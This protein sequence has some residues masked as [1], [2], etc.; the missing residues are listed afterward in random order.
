MRGFLSGAVFGVLI[1]A[2]ALIMMS[3]GN[4]M[5]ELRTE[6]PE[7]APVEVPA[8]SEFNRPP[9]ETDPVVPSEETAPVASAAPEVTAPESTM[10]PVPDTVPAGTPDL[11]TE[12]ETALDQPAAPEAGPEMALAT[13]PIAPTSETVRPAAPAAEAP[14]AVQPPDAETPVEVAAPEPEPAP[15][16]PDEGVSA[17]ATAETSAPSPAVAPGV[18]TPAAMEAAPV[19][20]SAPAAITSADAPALPAAPE[21]AP[22][23]TAAP[24]ENASTAIAATAPPAAPDAPS[25][26]TVASATTAPPSA[27]ESPAEEAEAEEPAETELAVPAAAESPAPLGLPEPG[28]NG[29]A[30]GVLTNRLPSIGDTPEI[31]EPAIEEEAVEDD[32]P[33][34]AAYAAPFEPAEGSPMMAILLLDPGPDLRPDPATLAEFPVR[35]TIGLDPSLPGAA[36][37]MRA[38]RAAGHEVAMLARVPE[39]AG[40]RDVEQSFQVYMDTVPQAVAVLDVPE[41]DLQSN[42]ARARQVTEILQATGQGLITYERGLNSGLQVANSAGVPAIAVFREFDNGKTDP[43]A[44]KRFLDVGAFRA[45]QEGAVLVSGQLRSETISTLTEWLLGSRAATVTVAPASAVLM[46]ME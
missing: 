45:A 8:G 36:D 40:P 35:L 15:A 16:A 30:S 21:A 34:L 5:V 4:R 7:A 22:D 24:E 33:A 38:Y 1:G 11:E 3:V 23:V 2:V 26:D 20:D 39:G 14:P 28:L 41:A 19:A 17:P 6:A 18:V 12:P 42:R 25:E 46:A 13:D 31:A 32:R 44:M 43:L 9:P 37:A 10:P 27:V 29:V